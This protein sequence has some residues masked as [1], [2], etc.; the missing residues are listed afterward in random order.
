MARTYA[1]TAIETSFA[2]GRTWTFEA[3]ALF[4]ALRN[5]QPFAELLQQRLCEA[6]AMKL[7]AQQ[8]LELQ[9][10]AHLSQPVWPGFPPA[11]VDRRIDPDLADYVDHGLVRWVGTGYR[12]TSKGIR[13]L[14]H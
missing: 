3:K 12:V 2:C 10:A 4:P 5:R 6:A 8:K 11:E 9:T 7:S 14:T 13:L 1:Q